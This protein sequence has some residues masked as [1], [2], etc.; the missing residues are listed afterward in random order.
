MYT[1]LTI[2]IILACILLILAVLIQNPKGGGIASNFSSSNQIMGVKRTTE[3]VEKFT[4]ILA[5]VLIG[6]SLGTN[7][8]RPSSENSAKSKSAIQE[9]IDNA[10][11]PS[12]PAPGNNAPAAAPAGAEQGQQQGQEQAQPQSNPEETK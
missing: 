5:F 10:Q 11:V 6:L 12:A 9:Q 3:F 7:F 2:I 4:W 8:F 1:I